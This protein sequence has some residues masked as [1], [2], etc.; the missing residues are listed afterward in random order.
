MSCVTIRLALA[1]IL[2]VLLGFVG[3]GAVL[4]LSGYPEFTHLRWN[5]IA[6][7]LRHHPVAFLIFPLLWTLFAALAERTER[8]AL[9]SG[10]AHMVGLIL[11][12]GILG[13]YLY[14]SL[15]PYTIPLLIGVPQ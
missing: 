11:A 10:V 12:A 4:K 15:H 13:A 14:A 9:S 1:Q 8:G 2:L 6:L 7:F 5:P 3:L